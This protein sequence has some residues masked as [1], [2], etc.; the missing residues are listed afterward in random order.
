MEQGFGTHPRAAKY[1]PDLARQA[2]LTY[3]EG[4][5]TPAPYWPVVVAELRLLADELEHRTDI[6]RI[7]AQRQEEN[8][9][10]VVCRRSARVIWHPVPGRDNPRA[11]FVC[12]IRS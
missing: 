4:M 1:A 7:K 6:A 3:V 11:S 10:L 8:V 5:P 2:V 9:G 12:A